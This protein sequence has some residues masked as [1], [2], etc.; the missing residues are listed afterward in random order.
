MGNPPFVGAKF[1]T[2]SQRGDMQEVAHFVD[3]G[4]LLDYVAG[5]YI[6]AADFIK[7]TKI[8]V[9]FVSTN[10]ITQGEQAATLWHALYERHMSILFAHRTF[11]WQSESRG[12]AH[13]HVVIIGFGELDLD[14]RKK[15]YDYGEASDHPVVSTVENISPYLIAGADRAVTS[16]SKPLCDAPEFVSGNK[17]IDD[18]N[19]L[20]TPEQKRDFIQTEPK[21]AHLFRRWYGGDEFLNGVV[22]WYL[23]LADT[24]LD[25]IRAMPAVW[26]RVQAVRKFR[27]D[28]KSKPTN[29]LAAKP[30][31]FHT[32]FSPTKPFLALPQVSSEKR[33]YI[34]MAFMRPKDLCGDKLRLCPGATL[35]HFGVLSSRMHMAWVKIVTGR[36]ESR[37]QWS[38]KLVYNNF[39]WPEKVNDVHR[40][41]V[42]QCAQAVLDAR[43][44]CLK[45]GESLADI[46]DPMMLPMQVLKAHRALDRAVDRAYRPQPFPSDVHRFEFLFSLYERLAA[47]LTA[48][49]KKTRH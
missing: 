14:S 2:E 3:N 12:K 48:P 8:K 47:P 26:K 39:P 25:E 7:G 30:T 41:R 36:L 27:T 10:S 35:Y 46:Y 33:T 17:P 40:A 16:R 9:A 42:E 32:E 24:P 22:R 37:F 43:E 15:I 18:G 44:P 38:V 49:A 4:G 45:A 29:A 19:Y 13:V 31:R 20:F 23:W 5:W 11:P 1:Q 34:P 6:K 28:S 21:S